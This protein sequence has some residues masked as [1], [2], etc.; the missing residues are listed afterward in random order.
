MSSVC[1]IWNRNE[2]NVFVLANLN[3]DFDLTVHGIE[4]HQSPSSTR[5][6]KLSDHGTM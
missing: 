1:A 5:R 3:S 6:K 2:L 4:H